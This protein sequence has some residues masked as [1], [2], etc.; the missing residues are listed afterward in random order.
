MLTS[1]S[2]FKGS[3]LAPIKGDFILFDLLID[4]G[5]ASLTIKGIKQVSFFFKFILQI[6]RK[7]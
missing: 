4:I 3:L 6:Y 5:S 7:Q 2:S 1:L